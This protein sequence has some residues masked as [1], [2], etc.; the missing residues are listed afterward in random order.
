MADCCRAQVVARAQ[1]SAF[2]ACLDHQ[3]ARQQ[4]EVVEQYDTSA[5]VPAEGDRLPA[6]PASMMLVGVSIGLQFLYPRAA[7]VLKA[8]A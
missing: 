1:E 4:L 2:L 3:R 8:A 5:Q 6:A 7:P